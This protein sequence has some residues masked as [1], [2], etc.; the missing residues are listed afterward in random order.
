MQINNVVAE[1]RAKRSASNRQKQEADIV[2]RRGTPP[3]ARKVYG[4]GS[5]QRQVEDDA[6]RQSEDMSLSDLIRDIRRRR[7]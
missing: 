1:E 7:G 5:M 2:A 6:R 4:D 3:K